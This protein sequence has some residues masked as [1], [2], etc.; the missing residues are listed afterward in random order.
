MEIAAATGKTL[1]IVDAERP[2]TGVDRIVS[3]AP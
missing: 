2:G 3:A 1:M